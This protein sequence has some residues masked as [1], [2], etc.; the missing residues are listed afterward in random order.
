MIAIPARIFP[1]TF[2]CIF[3]RVGAPVVK[4]AQSDDG[5]IGRNVAWPLWVISGQTVHFA[6]TTKLRFRKLNSFLRRA[7]V[8]DTNYFQQID[9]SHTE[10]NYAGKMSL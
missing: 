5:G 3:E 1:S 8:F 2:L 9:P 4:L 10:N 6:N 7:G